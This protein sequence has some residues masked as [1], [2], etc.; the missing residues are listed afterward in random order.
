MST[1]LAVRVQEKGQVTL[2][3]AVRKKLKL[4]KGDLVWIWEDE[5][6]LARLAEDAHW[7]FAEY[8]GVFVVDLMDTQGHI[9]TAP[10]NREFYTIMA[11][12]NPSLGARSV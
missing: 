4:K 11:R 3:K 5:N 8:S 6:T 10:E 12:H 1:S 7:Y 2:P 9:Y